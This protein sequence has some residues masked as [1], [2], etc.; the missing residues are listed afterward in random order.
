[1]KLT[2]VQVEVTLKSI[3]RKPERPVIYYAAPADENNRN[4]Y[5]TTDTSFEEPDEDPYSHYEEIADNYEELGRNVDNEQQYEISH[6]YFDI[7]LGQPD[8]N[9]EKS[10]KS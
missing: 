5:N 9:S 7:E 1:M 2:N 10:T 3:H 4:V 6:T 8:Q